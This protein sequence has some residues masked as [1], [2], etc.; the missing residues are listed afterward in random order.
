MDEADPQVVVLLREDAT[1]SRLFTEA[2]GTRYLHLA[3]HGLVNE[4]D[5]VA[6]SSLALTQPPVPV[7]DD[8]GFLTLNDLFENW[9]GRLKTT[10]LVVLSA[11]DSQR[12]RLSGDEGVFGLPWGFM[13]AGSTAVIA[14]LWQVDDASTAELMGDLY[15][16]IERTRPEAADSSRMAKLQAFVEVR[17]ALRQ[18]Y[19]EPF[20][21]AP[22]VYVGDPR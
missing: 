3:T 15:A 21:W 2:G 14:S 16:W 8:F 7:P 5:K 19:P 11:C 4:T 10:E 12:G 9:W 22:F 18:N 6:W 20:F 1:R 17:Q 13:Y